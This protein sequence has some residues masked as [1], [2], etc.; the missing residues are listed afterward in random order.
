MRERMRK[1]QMNSKKKRVTDILILKE[2]DGKKKQ[3]KRQL[4]SKEL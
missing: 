4:K 1:G 2:T 3:T